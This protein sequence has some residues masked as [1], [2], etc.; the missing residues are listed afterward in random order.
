VAKHAC[1]RVAFTFTFTFCRHSRLLVGLSDF[2]SEQSRSHLN[3]VSCFTIMRKN[4]EPLSDHQ[5][6]KKDFAQCI[7]LFSSILGFV[8]DWL[9]R[10]L[11][12]F[13]EPYIALNDVR[14][15]NRMHI[16]REKDQQDAHCTWQ[17]PTGCTLYVRK[18]NRMHIVREKDQQDA[19]FTRQRPTG[20]TFFSLS[21]SN[22]A[23]LYIFFTVVPCIWYSFIH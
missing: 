12:I 21:Y 7:L 14:K 15:T 16:V 5:L 10:W 6:L 13:S 23:I 19:H 1:T 2:N 9:H 4:F 17:R 20:C 8:Y 3:Y 22:S 11:V 18:T